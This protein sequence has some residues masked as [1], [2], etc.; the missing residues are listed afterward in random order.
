MLEVHVP[1][2]L[3]ACPIKTEVPDWHVSES[4]IETKTLGG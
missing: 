2:R 3:Y 1:R 4:T